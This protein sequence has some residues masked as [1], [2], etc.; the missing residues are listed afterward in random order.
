M[1]RQH[2][3]VRQT[4]KAADPEAGGVSVAS[5][6]DATV[7]TRFVG[8]GGE[9]FVSLE[10]QVALDRESEFAADGAKLE[11]AHQRRSLVSEPPDQSCGALRMPVERGE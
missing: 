2:K 10:V 7:R 3:R 8:V 6:D 11:K 5:S 9:G 4:G 1:Q